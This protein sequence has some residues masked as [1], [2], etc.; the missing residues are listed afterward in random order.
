MNAFALA[1]LCKGALLVRLE[2]QRANLKPGHS[3]I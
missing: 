1:K 2:S 3:E